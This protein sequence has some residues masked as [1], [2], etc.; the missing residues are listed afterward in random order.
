MVRVMVAG[1]IQQDEIARS[2]SIDDDTLRRHFRQQLDHGMSEANAQV[3]ANLFKQTKVNVRAAEFWLVNRDPQRWKNNFRQ[4]VQLTGQDGGPVQIETRN[5][6]IE[7]LMQLLAKQN[8]EPVT[9]EHDKPKK[10]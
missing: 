2:M 1:G 10:P 6:T 8:P 5:A 9:I 7:K 3:V 4:E